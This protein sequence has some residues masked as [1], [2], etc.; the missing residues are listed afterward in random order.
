MQNYTL[1]NF[2]FHCPNLINLSSKKFT[3]ICHCPILIKLN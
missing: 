3:Y 2:N 1:G